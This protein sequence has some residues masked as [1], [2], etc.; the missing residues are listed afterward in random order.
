MSPQI[1]QNNSFEVVQDHQRSREDVI[2][3]H[4]NQFRQHA[5]TSRISTCPR[6]EREKNNAAS[7]KLLN[8]QPHL[9]KTYS[10]SF[11]KEYQ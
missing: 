2:K 5:S 6:F 3:Q 1:E 11:K 4:W 10:T 7:S 9:F 8:F